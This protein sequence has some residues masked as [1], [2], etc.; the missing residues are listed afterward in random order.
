MDY[1]D[2]EIK[3]RPVKTQND[4]HVTK[5]MVNGKIVET[6]L[7]ELYA[8]LNDAEKDLVDQSEKEIK[9]AKSDYWK[10]TKKYSEK[11]QHSISKENNRKLDDLKDEIRQT[12]QELHTQKSFELAVLMEPDI[13]KD[14]PPE[15]GV[16]SSLAIEV[17]LN[18]LIQK[19]LILERMNTYLENFFETGQINPVFEDE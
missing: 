5:K 2:Q 13:A 4:K 11:A 19:L 9:S 18:Q 12:I 8:G 1:T 17:R 6:D 15:V 3:K 14:R 10:K 16:I 7:T